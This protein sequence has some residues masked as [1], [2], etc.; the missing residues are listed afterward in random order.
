MSDHE[1]F[2]AYLLKRLGLAVSAGACSL[3]IL[4]ESHS[5]PALKLTA[6]DTHLMVRRAGQPDGVRDLQRE[7]SVLKLLSGSGL[8]PSPVMYD[9]DRKFIVYEYLPG[10]AWSRSMLVDPGSLDALTEALAVLHAHQL[11]GT[12]CDPVRTLQ[13]YLVDADPALRSQLVGIA[14][15]AMESLH[16]RQPVLC[17]YD[18]WCGNI[19]QGSGTRFIDWEFA[20]GGAPM[21]DLATLVCYHGLDEDE[22]EDLWRSYS[23]RMQKQPPRQDLASWCSIVDCLTVAWSGFSIARG[24]ASGRS[25]PFYEPAFKRLGLNVDI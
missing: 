13:R 8:A 1:E 7:F 15:A 21:I 18:L 17:H 4:S 6:G 19:I 9:R 5:S 3:E 12:V 14:T 22:T 2:L 11:P 20:N 24:E 23:A 25:R 10:E 16:D